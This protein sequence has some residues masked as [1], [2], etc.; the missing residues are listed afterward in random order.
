MV[1]SSIRKVNE[2]ESAYVKDGLTLSPGTGDAV[3]VAGGTVCISGQ[4]YAIAAQDNLSLTPPTTTGYLRRNY[5]YVKKSDRTLGVYA[6]AQGAAVT[7]IDSKNL[8]ADS[9]SGTDGVDH[10]DRMYIGYIDLDTTP[11]FLTTAITDIRPML[12]RGA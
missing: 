2:F 5:V 4:P 7:A 10:Y 1:T 8:L 12:G 6:T 11:G 9:T 3:N